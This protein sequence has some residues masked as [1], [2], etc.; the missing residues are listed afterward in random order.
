MGSFLDFLNTLSP[1]EQQEVFAAQ[2]ASQAA[3]IVQMEINADLAAA[4]D[5]ISQAADEDSLLRDP[6]DSASELMFVDPL[7]ADEI[8]LLENQQNVVRLLE[9][10]KEML[11]NVDDE[12]KPFFVNR[13][14]ALTVQIDTLNATQI[15]PL[16]NK[17]IAAQEAFEKEKAKLRA[18]G[19]DSRQNVLDEFAEFVDKF[20]I[21]FGKGLTSLSKRRTETFERVQQEYISDVPEMLFVADYFIEDQFVGVLVCFEA[22]K[23]STHYE[24]F[25]RKHL[26]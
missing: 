6:F 8:K 1:E 10:E 24:I 20:E 16:L 12:L 13:I 18:E 14:V 9:S 4:I 2:A 7:T 15:Q 22:Y 21:I 17:R 5:A 23:S 26:C 25:K 11:E 19:N 3:A